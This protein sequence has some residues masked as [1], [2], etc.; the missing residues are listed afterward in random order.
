MVVEFVK[1]RGEAAFWQEYGTIE[2]N[3]Y[4]KVL[5]DHNSK[6]AGSINELSKKFDASPTYFMGFLDGINEKTSVQPF[7]YNKRGPQLLPEPC[8][9]EKASFCVYCMPAFAFQTPDHLFVLL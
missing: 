9:Y 1:Q 2:K 6:I 7:C 8:G 3:I 4:I 5:A